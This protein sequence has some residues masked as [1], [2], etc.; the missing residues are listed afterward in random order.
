MAG[1]RFF[2]LAAEKIS[3]NCKRRDR[4]CNWWAFAER[5]S[6][7]ARHCNVIWL[8]EMNSLFQ[9]MAA[10]MM[11]AGILAA[12]MAWYAGPFLIGS[13]F[14]IMR[15]W[16]RS[17]IAGT[18]L[19]ISLITVTASADYLYNL[20]NWTQSRL[21]WWMNIWICFFLFSSPLCLILLILLRTA[22]GK[23][24]SL[25][26]AALL[27]G[28]AFS[29]WHQW[30][31]RVLSDQIPPPLTIGPR[32]AASGI[33]LVHCGR[34]PNGRV[35][36]Q[37]HVAASTAVTLLTDPFNP[38]IAA[39]TCTGTASTYFPPAKDPALWG[40]KTEV[41]NLQ[42]YDPKAPYFLAVFGQPVALYRQLQAIPLSSPFEASILSRPEI[43]KTMKQ[44]N[45]DAANFDPTQAKVQAASGPR[46]E[47]LWITELN[48]LRRPPDA[49]HCTNPALILSIGNVSNAQLLLPY[50][51]IQWNAFE[52]NDS[53]YFS[54]ITQQPTPPGEEIM[55]PDQEYHIFRVNQDSLE[56]VLL[57]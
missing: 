55:N 22:R 41:S 54:A 49:F 15:S 37:G 35:F 3:L 17:W 4:R 30:N 11:G 31:T 39:Q 53:M 13:L 9:S 18:A 26:M 44:Y 33:L 12:I 48:P 10:F 36:L 14:F 21:P 5:P 40:N 19:L 16:Y 47:R 27:A 38:D 7:K 57:K 56:L 1:C 8:I 32:N 42:G 51:A 6:K 24:W 34:D 46:G 25:A 43:Q 20:S 28:T 50:C 45:Y 52:L 2:P 29:V 23:F